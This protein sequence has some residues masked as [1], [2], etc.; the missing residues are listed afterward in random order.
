MR[1]LVRQ[2]K[3]RML[4]RIACACAVV[5]SLVAPGQ[6]FA[7]DCG[8][9]GPPCR[10]FARTAAVFAGWVTRIGTI[11]TKLASGD[12]YERILVSFE[13]ERSYRGA[14]GTSIEVVTD[15][16]GGDC[17][18]AFKQGQRYLVYASEFPEVGKLYT[19]ICS[20]TREISEAEE[21]LEYLNHKDD[22]G[23]GAGIE[24]TINELAR[25]PKDGT[26]TWITGPAVGVVVVIEGEEGRWT[27]VT[28]KNGRFRQW[29]LKPG[30]YRVSPAFSDRFLPHTETAV[31]EEML[32]ARVYILATPPP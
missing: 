24:G 4:V 16:G 26:R 9:P 28:D 2:I 18:Y 25:D 27:A 14:R 5:A 30:K 21:D 3:S 1:E 6:L 19:S 8:D 17:A 31:V 32:C 15:G 29:G 10:A 22:A 7:C 11:S 12:A 23:H 13:I 20:R